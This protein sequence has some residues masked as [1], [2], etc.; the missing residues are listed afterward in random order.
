MRVSANSFYKKLGFKTYDCIDLDNA[1]NA[2]PYN[3]NLSFKESY[4]FTNQF[5]LVTNLG[6]TEHII[7]QGICFENIHNLCKK[8]GIMLHGLPIYGGLNHG[9]FR[10]SMKFFIR[11]AVFNGYEFLRC[12]LIESGFDNNMNLYT[13]EPIRLRHLDAIDEIYQYLKSSKSCDLSFPE[14]STGGGFF[15]LLAF[16][17]LKNIS[18]E[19]PLDMPLVENRANE[20]LEFFLGSKKAQN[21]NR[22]AIFGTGEAAR[23]ARLFFEKCGKQIIC[24][25]DDFKN[26]ELNGLPIIN[27]DT[28][29]GKY[30]NRCDAIIKGPLQKGNIEI[31]AGVEIDIIKIQAS[32]F[33]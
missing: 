33:H 26:G 18:F 9:F 14:T 20:T 28:F 22:V 21:I 15:I 19:L 4:S 29:V 2:L 13:R 5:D 24:Y 3:L 27:F 23:L 30:Q 12:E 17:K 25:I 8:D 16:K 31:R 7:N 32:W 1:Y 6:T 11:L 10:Y